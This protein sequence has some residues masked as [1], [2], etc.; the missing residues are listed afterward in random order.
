MINEFEHVLSRNTTRTTHHVEATKI[1][2]KFHKDVQRLLEVLRDVNPF[3]D[4]GHNLKCLD[5]RDVMEK[6]IT[7][8]RLMDELGKG[9]H[10]ALVTERL[11]K[12]SVPYSDTVHIIS[13]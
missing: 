6:V 3:T 12:F 7:S 8:Y 13:F 11:V 5:T 1:Q 10:E 9:L 2:L 4:E